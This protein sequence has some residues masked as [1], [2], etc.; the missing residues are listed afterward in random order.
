GGRQDWR[1]EPHAPRC[2]IQPA[3][4]GRR[5][6]VEQL[7]IR[8]E[9]FDLEV[10]KDMAALL[11]IGNESVGRAALADESFVTLGPTPLSIEVLNGR[12]AFHERC[13]FFHQLGLECA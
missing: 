8:I 3:M 10:A 7:A 2:T 1:L 11:V 13:L 5:D 9:D 4:L 12:W 6:C